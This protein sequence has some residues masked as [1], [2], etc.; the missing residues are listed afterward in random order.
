MKAIRTHYVGPSNFHGSRVIASDSDGNRVNLGWDDAL[1]SDEN[2]KAAQVALCKK[3]KWTGEMVSG[4][5]CN[6][7]YWVFL[8]TSREN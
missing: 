5:H 7:H 2:H 8:P 4:E 3:M 1:N 6:S